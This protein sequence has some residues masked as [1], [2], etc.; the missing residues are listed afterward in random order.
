MNEIAHD[1]EIGAFG[2]EATEGNAAHHDDDDQDRD[3]DECAPDRDLQGIDPLRCGASG[4]GHC[5]E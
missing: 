4:N 1:L 2:N 5:G 3:A